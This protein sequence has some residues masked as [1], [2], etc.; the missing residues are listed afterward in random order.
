M[1]ARRDDK[2]YTYI[3]VRLDYETWA[4]SKELSAERGITM[5]VLVGALIKLVVDGKIK[6]NPVFAETVQIERAP[7]HENES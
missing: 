3:N 2:K 1:K 5:G 7:S 4:K 6:V